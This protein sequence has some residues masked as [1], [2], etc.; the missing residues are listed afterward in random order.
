MRPFK[1]EHYYRAAL[2]RMTQ[3]QL[4]Y[5]HQASYAVAMYVA[6]VA[7]ECMLRA[8]KGRKDSVFHEKHDLPQLF[9]ASGILEVKQAT[10]SGTSVTE[11]QIGIY[12]RTLQAA[13]I[14]ISILWSNDYR[15]ASEDRLRAHLRKKVG[16][17]TG[18]KGDILKANAVRLLNAAQTFVDK[19][20]RLWNLY[21]GK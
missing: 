15:Y 9:R 8:F 12:R 5:R 7:V 13:M 3:A 21:P 16:L 1:P 6:G 14:D 19:G 20:S 17:R 11:T 10:Q 18:I 2:E 4:L